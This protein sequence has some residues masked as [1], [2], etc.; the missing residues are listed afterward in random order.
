[1]YGGLM[2]ATAKASTL[3]D[4]HVARDDEELIHIAN[5]YI[6]AGEEKLRIAR[7]LRNDAVRRQI[8][9]LGPTRAARQARMPLSTI[10][11]IRGGS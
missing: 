3:D 6:T 4:L 1:M 8:Q 10:K 2:T 11:A 7:K 9:K 5:E